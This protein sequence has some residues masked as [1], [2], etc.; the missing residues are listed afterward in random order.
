MLRR[1]FIGA[2][3][4]ARA[5]DEHV[6]G[7]GS[8]SVR[9]EDGASGKWSSMVISGDKS[10]RMR[11]IR[12]IAVALLGASAISC[13]DVVRDGRSP[14]FVVIDALQGAKGNTP[15]L[16]SGFLQSDVLTLV[17]SGGVCSQTSPCDLQ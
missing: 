10:M 9:G 4:R 5:E 12:A 13:G 6:A 3:G 8:A 7:G 14:A 17:T 2:S 11:S 1:G 16:F 15:A